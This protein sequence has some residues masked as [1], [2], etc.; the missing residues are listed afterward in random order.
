MIE[1]IH[2]YK[3][4]GGRLPNKMIKAIEDTTGPMEFDSESVKEYKTYDKEL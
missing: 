3:R 4:L 2:V 1:F